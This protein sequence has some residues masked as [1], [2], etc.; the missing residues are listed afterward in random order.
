MAVMRDILLSFRNMKQLLAGLVLLIVVGI[1]GFLFRNTLEHPVTSLATSTAPQACTTEAKVCPDGTSVGR[2]GANCA[3]AACALP[4]AEDAAIHLAFVIPTGYIANADAIGADET[5]RAVFDKQSKNPQ[6]PHTIVIR[7][8]PIPAG[9]TAT[10][11]IL[12]NTMYESSGNQPKSLSEFSPKLIQGKTFYCVTL[13]RFEGQIHT[14]CYL[15]RAADVLRF[16]VLEK[17]VVDWTNPKLVVDTLP[18]HKAFYGMLA[19]VQ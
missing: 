10:S 7:D 8:Y 16:E 2:S 15:P 4:N 17:D 3:F 13:E 11:T 9:K 18:E 12:A 6:T 1:G 14:A 19:T 5:L